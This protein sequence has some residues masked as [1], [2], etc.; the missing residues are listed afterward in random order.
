MQQIITST[1][2]A[3]RV[4]AYTHALVATVDPGSRQV[5]TQHSIHLLVRCCCRWWCKTPR[6]WWAAPR[7]S[8]FPCLFICQH[9]ALLWLGMKNDVSW[10]SDKKCVA[11]PSKSAATLFKLKGLGDLLVMGNGVWWCIY[12]KESTRSLTG[13]PNKLMSQTQIQIVHL[14][15]RQDR[16]LKCVY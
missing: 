3:V 13:M 9:A 11:A 4:V 5:I 2:K 10:W 8:L 1:C 14:E 12:V 16:G 6:W 15:V 7:S